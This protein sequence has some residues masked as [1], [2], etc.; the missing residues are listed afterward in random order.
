MASQNRFETLARLFSVHFG[1][2]MLS[3]MITLG[4]LG[5]SA[6]QVQAAGET[7]TGRVTRSADNQPVSGVVVYADEFDTNT[8]AA[9]ATTA[10]DG[11]YT[12]FVNPGTYRVRACP[13]CSGSSLNLANVFAGGTQIYDQAQPI[14][15]ET[16]QQYSLDFSLDP[17][18]SISGVISDSGNQPI[19]GMTVAILNA[20]NQW[21]DAV[22][23]EAD[24]SYLL[25]GIPFGDFKVLACADCNGPSLYPNLYYGGAYTFETA[26]SITVGA[27]SSPSNIDISLPLG[28]TIQGKVTDNNIPGAA[29]EG[30]TIAAIRWD[31]T[32]SQ[33]TWYKSVETTTDGSYNLSGLPDGSYHV[34]ACPE[35][36][37][38]VYVGEYYNDKLYLEESQEI[39][40][41]NG[42]SQSGIDFALVSAAIIAGHVTASDGTTALSNIP[43]FVE[44]TQ[45]GHGF[46]SSSDENGNYS[47]NVEPGY[48]RLRTMVEWNSD[49]ASMNYVDQIYDHALNLEEAPLIQAVLNEPKTGYD[50]TLQQ[51]GI[52]TGTI[53]DVSD[54]SLENA[55]VMAVAADGSRRSF[56]SQPTGA[57]GVYT[58]R[59]LPAGEYVIRAMH[60][61]SQSLYYG[62][63][64]NWNKDHIVTITAGETTENINFQL[65]AQGGEDPNLLTMRQ[66]ATIAD[67]YDPGWVEYVHNAYLVD[68][69]FAGMARINPADGSTLSNLSSSWHSTDNIHWTFTLRGGLTWSDG[70][71]L[72]AADVRFALLRNLKMNG[73]VDN[74]MIIQGAE[75][76]NQGT[77]SAD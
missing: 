28:N 68:Q 20:D 62:G 73:V 43:I 16:D 46:S 4:L 54:A 35:C 74:M 38:K 42:S 9:E 22:L 37:G 59:G 17:G 13:G 55:T 52:L 58:L 27:D 76:Y 14:Q 1:R 41:Q 75:A 49:L 67:M 50:F 34:Q 30:V 72:T 70:S 3:V 53:T 45:N 61:G 23:T 5:V 64:A 12:L 40:L 33:W 7:I 66:S 31:E 24:G 18:G 32:T 11:S 71:P 60:E 69:I 77:A 48:Y 15:V 26:T 51:G 6:P 39:S 47:I 56:G 21:V 19:S 8:R 10:S 57:D 44:N 65:G 36:T 63:S 25:S 2:I 29:L